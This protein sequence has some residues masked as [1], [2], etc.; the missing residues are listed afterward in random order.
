MVYTAASLQGCGGRGRG[1]LLPGRCGNDKEN[2]LAEGSGPGVVPVRSRHRPNP[3]P[4][5][6]GF[7]AAHRPGM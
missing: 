3:E 4:R 2:G 6:S 7:D 1:G 5:E